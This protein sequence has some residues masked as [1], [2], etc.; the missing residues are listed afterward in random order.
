MESRASTPA[1]SKG[2]GNRRRTY[3]ISPEVQWK[4]IVSIMVMVFAVSA[5]ITVLTYGVIYQAVRASTLQG[6]AA[7]AGHTMLWMVLCG[8]GFATAPALALGFWCLFVSHRIC[9]PVRVMERDLQEFCSGSFPKQR[10][11]R[12]RD[13]FKGLHAELWRALNIVR[14]REEAY[15]AS[16]A[17]IWR[18]A[19]G[20]RHPT[21]ASTLADIAAEAAPFI[22][23]SVRAKEGVAAPGPTAEVV[24]P[25]SADRESLIEAG[26]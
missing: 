17:R 18:M 7:T 3:L 13:Y 9:G 8:L 6:A 21:P 14:N 24:P 19:Q 22:E 10:P 1:A 5:L 20:P 16:L 26:R 4:W 11:L 2:R 25:R 15:R 23:E 12:K